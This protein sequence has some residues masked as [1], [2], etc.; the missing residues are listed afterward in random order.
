MSGPGTK[1]S[2]I[3]FFNILFSLIPRIHIERF[4]ARFIVSLPHGKTIR[5]KHFQEEPADESAGQN[6]AYNLCQKTATKANADR[7]TAGH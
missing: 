6:Q 3:N 7:L 4:D 5:A 1:R 2:F